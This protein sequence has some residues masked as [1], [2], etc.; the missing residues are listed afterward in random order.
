[1][2]Q[3]IEL[4]E[5]KPEEEVE[6]RSPQSFGA[7]LGNFTKVH[8]VPV[9]SVLRLMQPMGLRLDVGTNKSLLNRKLA[10][11]CDDGLA[12]EPNT[13]RSELRTEIR[14]STPLGAAL[15]VALVLQIGFFAWSVCNLKRQTPALSPALAETESVLVNFPAD[16][17]F[18][19][20]HRILLRRVTPGVW[21]CL[22]PDGEVIRHDLTLLRHIVLERATE[23]PAAVAGD[24]YAFDPI[25]RV[26]I[27][28]KKRLA[29]VQA[30]VLGEDEPGEV[31]TQVWIVADP[32]RSDYGEQV[33][34]DLM[35]DP[36]TGMAFETK[37]VVTL[38]GEEV[39]VQRMSTGLHLDRAGRRRLD[40][41]DA[42]Q[43]M[44][45]EELE[46]FPATEVLRLMIGHDQLNTP[47]LAA[48]EQL[49]R[50]LVQLEEPR[51]SGLGI[52]LGGPVSNEGRAQTRKFNEHLTN[53]L[54]ERAQIWKSE[55]QF[56]E[57]KRQW[58]Q[59]AATSSRDAD[60]PDGKGA[61]K[62]PKGKGKGGPKGGGRGSASAA[63][64]GA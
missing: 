5:A 27:E 36:N 42:V 18:T 32:A 29:A 7:W 63:A 44:T 13:C 30:S 16:P 14:Y 4:E 64:D 51:L 10:E 50:W 23:F 9:S 59:S 15:Q 49:V 25:S 37:G 61:E 35:N 8:K 53:K 46:D 62:K 22:T 57:E 38:N 12:A 47:S 24:V 2:G 54:K 31:M 41:S 39:F 45:E 17:H 1:M 6:E 26:T 3:A 40:L 34:G 48:G 52:I 56:R 58:Q 19:W 55:R 60:K 33:A 11:I 28:A 21:F 20:H 43:L